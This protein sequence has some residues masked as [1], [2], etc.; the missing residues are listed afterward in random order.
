MI[1]VF[2]LSLN[3]Q[4]VVSDDLIRQMMHALSYCEAT[5]MSAKGHKIFSAFG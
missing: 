3:H 5:V 2:L 4:T 1:D